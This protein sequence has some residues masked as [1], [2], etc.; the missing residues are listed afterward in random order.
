LTRS[1]QTP[2]RLKA[3]SHKELVNFQNCSIIEN[4]KDPCL[5]ANRFV[6]SMPHARDEWG[7]V[8]LSAYIY[9]L[10]HGGALPHLFPNDGLKD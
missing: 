2:E 9:M 7:V 4:Q 5:T 8:P 10:R 3:A 1:L 6:L